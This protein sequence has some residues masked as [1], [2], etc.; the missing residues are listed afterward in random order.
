MGKTFSDGRSDCWPGLSRRIPQDWL[1][2]TLGVLMRGNTTL[3]FSEWGCG[4]RGIELVDKCD[5]SLLARRSSP[6]PPPLLKR[7]ELD[8]RELHG[9]SL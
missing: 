6:G 4:V 1:E 7:I 5:L 9:N 8:I 3:E 2:S